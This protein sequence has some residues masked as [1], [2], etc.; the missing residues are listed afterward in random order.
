MATS[1]QLNAPIRVTSSQL[2]ANIL[3]VDD[4]A[5][6]ILL[7]KSILEDEGYYN[8]MTTVDSRQV[9]SLVKEF[10]PD[11]ILLDLMMPH[12]DGYAVMEQ[13]RLIIPADTYLPILVLTADATS[14]AKQR[15]LG[16]G[17][18]DFLTKPFDNIEVLLRI[19]NLLETRSLHLHQ[20]RQNQTL[21]EKIN[22]RTT[23]IQRQLERLSALHTINAVIA[24]SLDLR[25][26][27]NIALEHVVT[28][29]S[30]DAADILLLNPHSQILEYAA[31]RGFQSKAIEHSRLRLG[32]GSTGC[33]VLDRRTIYIPDLSMVAK[34]FVRSDLLYEEGFISYCGAPLIAK[35]EV[36]GVFEVFFRTPYEAGAEWLDFME[37]LVRQ[38]AIAVDNAQMFTNLQR[39]NIDLLMAYD[40]TIE[41]WS[42][43]LDLRDNETSGHTQRVAEM[44]ERLALV[45]GLS[46]AEIVHVRRGALLHDIGKM[47][48][49]DGILLKPGPLTDQ[50]WVTMRKHPV[51]AYE[52]LSQ[53]NY[54]RDTLDIPYCHHE[55]W[56]GSGYPRSLKGNEIPLSARIFS[57]VDVWDALTND[58]PYRSAWSR[59]KTIDY[60]KDQSGTHFDPQVVKAFMQILN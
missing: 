4:Q 15:A 33:A 44:T 31:G 11:L 7:L 6:N 14:Q 1:L 25:L 38:I 42:K 36:R 20:Q 29:L 13:L 40:A 51:Y 12:L 23:Q 5:S 57:I 41:S 19:K 28:Q 32:E 21:E 3:I 17:A 37:T 27:L 58:R 48:I 10:Q 22:E 55:K 9:I 35:G 50:E 2:N 46:D 34:D 54:L 26:T 56:D 47:G 52:L 49:P 30:V 24:G 8:L 53:I 18:K 43:A 16:M 45:M 59:Q 60:I 39:S